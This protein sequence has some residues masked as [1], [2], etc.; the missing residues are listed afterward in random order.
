[1]RKIYGGR[2]RRGTVKEKFSLSGARPSQRASVRLNARRLPLAVAARALAHAAATRKPRTPRL[3][4]S[5]V[6]LAISERLPSSPLL[7]PALGCH[8]PLPAGPARAGGSIPRHILIELEKMKIVEKSPEG[9]R[10]GR[11]VTETG[12]RDL[13]SIAGQIRNAN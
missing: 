6:L 12:Q 3:H 1:M 7:P 8:C 4:K 10:G 9:G 2:Q 11:R 5:V 13:D